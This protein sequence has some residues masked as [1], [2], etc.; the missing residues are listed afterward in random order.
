MLGLTETLQ[1]ADDSNL[2]NSSFLHPFDLSQKYSNHKS[3]NNET[4][5]EDEMLN[6]KRKRGR[7]Q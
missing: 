1:R 7:K 5:S 2:D 6:S 3:V 4:Q